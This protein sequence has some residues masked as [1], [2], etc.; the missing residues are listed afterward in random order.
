[1]ETLPI[2]DYLQAL[3]ELNNQRDRLKQ[4][5]YEIS[6]F[7]DIMRGEATPNESATSQQIRSKFTS[8]RLST[9]QQE[10]Q[11][12]CRDNI[13]IMAEIISGQF[14]D[15]TILTIAGYDLNNINPEIGQMLAQALQLLRNNVKR[16]FSI[17]VQT[18]STLAINGEA[19]KTDRIELINMSSNFFNMAIGIAERMPEFV[20]PAMQMLRFGI[21]AFRASQ[22]IQAS[23]DESIQ[24]Y[25]QRKE[26]E[27]QQPPQIPVEIQEMQMKMQVEQQKIQMEMQTKQAELQKDWQ[28]SQMK[29]QIKQQEL[30]QDAYEMQRKEM[31]E[32]Q[33][34]QAQFQLQME[35]IRGELMLLREK[36]MIEAQTQQEKA[37]IEGRIKQD[38][39]QADTQIKGAKILSDAEL[40]Q[41]K[42]MLDAQLKNQKHQ[43]DFKAKVIGSS[44]QQPQQ[45][46]S[47]IHINIDKKK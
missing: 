28:D 23:L 29:F 19:E 21:D 2:R 35:K 7:S 44:Q 42:M 5:F 22:P 12:F 25:M 20:N 10:M 37:M 15:E 40:A 8:L 47:Q 36:G 17:D 1:L 32:V 45:T 41:Q 43:T 14:S 6:G 38:K 30:Q 9:R 46:P 18:D 11:R 26:Q 31:L 16:L 39:N 4:D 27:A 33:K 13:G 34:M 3:T 24:Q